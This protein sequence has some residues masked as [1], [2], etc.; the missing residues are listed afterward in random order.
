M[1]NEWLD[2]VDELGMV[3]VIKNNNNINV[4]IDSNKDGNGNIEND[5]KKLFNE[6]INDKVQV[7]PK[8]CRQAVNNGLLNYKNFLD[9]CWQLS[10]F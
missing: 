3:F 6:Y 10:K 1:S 2:D 9:T 4:I 8:H 7:T 5:N